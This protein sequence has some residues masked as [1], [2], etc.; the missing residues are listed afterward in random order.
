MST[1]GALFSIGLSVTVEHREEAVFSRHD[2]PR[3]RA[4][5]KSKSLLRISSVVHQSSVSYNPPLPAFP[6]CEKPMWK[7]IVIVVVAWAVSVL[8]YVEFFK[9]S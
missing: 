9:G 6:V 4:A 2:P 5:A 8:I 1:T 7:K 3:G